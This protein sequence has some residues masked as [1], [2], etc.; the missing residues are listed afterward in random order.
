METS[1]SVDAE[2]ACRAVQ[3]VLEQWRGREGVIVFGAGAHTRK[4]LP[5]LLACSARVAGIVDDSPAR[6]GDR[7][8]V[9]TVQDPAELI[10]DRSRGILVSSDSQHETLAARLQAAYGDEHVILPLYTATTRRGGEPS[11]QFTGER[12]TGRTL[13]EIE[14][15]HRARY[16]W[17]LQHINPRAL[18]LDAACGNGYGS[19]ILAA[20][21]ARVVGVD[22]ADD[23]IAFAK[24][25][26]GGEDIA[27]SVGR[28]DDGSTLARIGDEYGP[29]DAVVSLET[30]EHLEDPHG[31]L[32]SAFSLL[33]PGGRLFCSTP[34]AETMPIDKVPFHRAHL[35][36]R[37]ATKLLRSIGFSSLRWFGQEGMQILC[38]RSTASQ[39]YCLY[40]AIKPHACHD[41]R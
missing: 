34:N 12:Q 26:F 1:Q 11:L 19:R 31:F 21:G 18:V 40:A 30:I 28:L 37:A 16:Y 9:W 13:E 14:V 36:A 39:R 24:Y 2:S 38:G 22:I 4:T 27:F 3:R 20:G 35:S 25:H 15:G 5:A 32:S 7:V 41:V 29:F 17:A 6:W 10:G 23:A 33:R 8:G